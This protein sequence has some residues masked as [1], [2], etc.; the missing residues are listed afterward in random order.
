[1]LPIIDTRWLLFVR[2]ASSG[3]LSKAATLLDMPQSMVSRNITQLEQQC[4][5]RLFRRTGR[6]VVLTEFG[7]QMLPRVAR[8]VEDAD[9][10]SDDIRNARGQPIG[11]VLVGLLPSAV[12]Q[13]AAP[14]FAITREQLPGVRLHLVE[15]ASAQLEEQLRDG[16]L[17]MAIVLRED[18]ASL[19]GA[20][21]LARVPLHLV[22]CRGDELL[23]GSDVPLSALSRIPLV[24]PSRPHLLRARL[25]HLAADHSLP[26]HVAV[27]AD[28]VRLQCE[29]AAAGGGYA[30]A[31][32]LPGQLDERLASSRIVQ[33]VLERFVVLAESPHR[34]HTRATLE[35]RRLVHLVAESPIT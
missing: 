14:L 3:S 8:L 28:S 35:V 25:D 34:P 18:E 1:M 11:E 24:V 20:H 27:E 23:R 30:I 6:G 29:I 5:Q 32:V 22:G 33:P 7:A 17:D 15:G 9:A 21:L 10:L 31:S 16:R 19:G 4:G 13:F 12:G 26:L 2:V